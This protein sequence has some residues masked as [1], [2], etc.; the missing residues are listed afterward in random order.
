[1]ELKQISFSELIAFSKLLEKAAKSHGLRLERHVNDVWVLS[2]RWLPP[3]VIGEVYLHQDTSSYS[4]YGRWK[5]GWARMYHFGEYLKQ[6]SPMRR[7]LVGAFSGW[8]IR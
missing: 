7:R 5:F 6:N 2:F 4:V 1:M 3:V 8:H